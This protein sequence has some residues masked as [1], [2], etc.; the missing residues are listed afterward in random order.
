MK[1]HIS[2]D[3]MVFKEPLMENGIN[4]ELCTQA[5]NSPDINLQDWGFFRAIQSFN[6]AVDT[7]GQHSV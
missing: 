2:V 4:G 1:N 3:D 5:A 6:D 7:C